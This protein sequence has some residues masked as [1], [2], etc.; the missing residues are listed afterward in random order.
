MLTI[1]KCII[2]DILLFSLKVTEA[3]SVRRTHMTRMMRKPMRF[4]TTLMRGWMRNDE[5][6][7]RNDWK[8]N[9]NVTDRNDQ[10]YSS[11]SRTWK[12]VFVC[13][14]I[15][16]ILLKCWLCHTWIWACQI[17]MEKI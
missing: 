4:T 2:G 13:I 8:K 9:S 12:F 15:Y 1:T 6:G 14:H 7:A 16:H 3:A 5:T 11:S 10:R 17:D